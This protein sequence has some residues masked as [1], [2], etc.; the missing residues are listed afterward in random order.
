MARHDHRGRARLRG[1]DAAGDEPEA[2][3]GH[4]HLEEHL[5]GPDGRAE[6]HEGRDRRAGVESGADLGVGRAV[7]GV[8]EGLVLV[9]LRASPKCLIII[10]DWAVE[11]SD[12]KYEYNTS[13]GGWR[14]RSTH[15][16]F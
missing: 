12:T 16:T 9:G 3:E 15:T 1:D 4:Q 8:K 5:G 11:L 14:R 13:D 7:A 2:P 6:R 10:V